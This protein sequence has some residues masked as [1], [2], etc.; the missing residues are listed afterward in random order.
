MNL[1]KILSVQNCNK[2]PKPLQKKQRQPESEDLR[3]L[4]PSKALSVLDTHKQMPAAHT[5]TQPLSFLANLSSFQSRGQQTSS[6]NKQGSVPSSTARQGLTHL[7]RPHYK[8]AHSP[9]SSSIISLQCLSGSFLKA[10]FFPLEEMKLDCHQPSHA[11]STFPS[12]VHY[13][14]VSCIRQTQREPCDEKIPQASVFTAPSKAM[15]LFTF[16]AIKRAK[17][18]R[19]P[20]N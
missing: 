14:S 19:I 9:T 7:C 16:L 3:V 13:L 8:L 4:K 15:F 18:L 2:C 11:D 17:Q 10:C 6:A 5:H 1:K 20:F 12:D